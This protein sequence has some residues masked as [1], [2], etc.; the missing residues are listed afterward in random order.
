MIREHIDGKFPETT[1][2]DMSRNN[3]HI[4]RLTGGQLISGKQHVTT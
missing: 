1:A 2:A 4:N 3:K